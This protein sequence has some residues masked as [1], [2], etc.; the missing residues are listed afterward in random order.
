[1]LRYSE[2]NKKTEINIEIEALERAAHRRV[3]SVTFEIKEQAVP[4][5]D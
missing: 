4:D 1:M 2:I 3:T 5:G